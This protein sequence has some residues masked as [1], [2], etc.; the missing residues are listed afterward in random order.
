MRRA[1]LICK[2]KDRSATV[3]QP[4]PS[5][6]KARSAILAPGCAR[7]GT[8]GEYVFAPTF[9]AAKA[10]AIKNR[11]EAAVSRCR[12]FVTN[13]LRPDALWRPPT[14]PQ[15]L[16]EFTFPD[17]IKEKRHAG[18]DHRDE[19]PL[20]EAHMQCESGDEIDGQFR[21]AM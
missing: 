5:R 11:T 6:A 4:A 15:N 19:R 2:I 14:R 7:K 3:P 1:A 12:I 21:G 16:C 18:D 17:Q 10:A 9:A 13:G 8:P 20:A